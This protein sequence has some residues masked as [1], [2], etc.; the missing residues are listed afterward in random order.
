[1]DDGKLKPREGADLPKVTQP[2]GLRAGARSQALPLNTHFVMSSEAWW[3]YPVV[4]CWVGT[5]SCHDCPAPCRGHT[6]AAA[7]CHSGHGQLRV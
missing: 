6:G 7:E 2:V 4:C 1:M 3:V 5:T